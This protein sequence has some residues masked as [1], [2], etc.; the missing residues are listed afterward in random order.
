MSEQEFAKAV[1]S[2]REGRAGLDEGRRRISDLVE[3]LQED[4]SRSI[5]EKQLAHERAISE[6][7]CKVCAH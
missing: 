6:V 3:S 7:T 2:W 1:Q 4:F 5:A